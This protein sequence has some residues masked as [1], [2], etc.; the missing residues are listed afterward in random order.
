M[1]YRLVRGG[2]RMTALIGW[3]L[4]VLFL[5]VTASATSRAIR[6]RDI[7]PIGPAVM[8]AFAAVFTL[9]VLG[10]I[11]VTTAIAL[12]LVTFTASAVFVV[13]RPGEAK[14]KNARKKRGGRVVRSA[15]RNAAGGFRYLAGDGKAAVDRA[16]AARRLRD[17]GHDTAQVKEGIP[18]TTV[19]SAEEFRRIPVAEALAESLGGREI[20]HLREDKALGDLPEPAALIEAAA[21]AMP[22]PW[23]ELASWIAV[24]EPDTDEEEHVFIRGTAAG[25]MAVAQAMESHADLLLNVIGLDPAAVAAVLDLC[26]TFTA[27]AQDAALADRRMSLVYIEIR[28]WLDSTGRHLPHRARQWFG[29]GTAA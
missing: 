23:A 5:A 24:Q 16:R 20:P 18:L 27:A 15:G 28:E 26:D 1:G 9:G 6:G 17:P 7:R 19:E 2:V 10:L 29:R 14:G 13:S 11:G 25:M 8:F 12:C 4:A 21:R 3:I 22:V